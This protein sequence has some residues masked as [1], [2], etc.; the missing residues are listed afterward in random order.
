MI[1]DFNK[2]TPGQELQ[3]GTLWV[4]EEMPGLVVGADQTDTLWRLGYW[5]SFNIPFYPEVSPAFYSWETIL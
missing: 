5:P 3:N 2:F 4:I 1:V